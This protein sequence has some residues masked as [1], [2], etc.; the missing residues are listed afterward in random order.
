MSASVSSLVRVTVDGKFFRLGEKK[1][2]V[3]GVSYGPFAPDASGACFASPERTA[4]DFALA[5]ELGANVLRVYYVPPRWFLD[6]AARHDLRVWV[7]IPWNKHLCFLDSSQRRQEALNAVRQAVEGCG[8]HPA[9]FAFSVANEIPADIVRWSGARRVAEFIDELAAEAKRIDP[10]CL[11]TYGNFPPTEFLRPQALDFVSFNVYLH[12]RQPFKNYLARL[13]MIADA[14]PLVLGE[15]GVDSE[16]EGEVNKA[17]MLAWQIEDAFRGGL[18]GTVVFS[19]TDDWWRGGEKILDWSMG[20]TNRERAPKE[21]FRAVQELYALD[22]PLPLTRYPM[23]SVVVATYD[24]GRTLRACLDSLARLNYPNYEVILVDDGST[25]DTPRIVLSHPKIHYHRHPLNLGL[26]A[27]RNTGIG[28]A[29]GDIVAFTDSDCRPDEDWLHYLVG[30]L[31]ESDFA[32]IGGHNLLPP[33]ASPVSSAVMVSPGGPAHVMLTDRQAEHVPGCNMAFY[34]W[35]LEEIH[36]FDPIFRK[37]GDDVDLCWRLQ[38]R[39]WRIG[40][41][42]AGFVW[43]DRRST[44]GAYLRQQS[45]YGEAEALLVQKHPEYFSALGGGIWHGRIYASSKHGIVMQQPIVYHGAFASGM[46]QTLYTSEPVGILSFFTSLEY[47]VLVTLPLL[48][49]ATAFSWLMP[50]AVTSFALSLGV[51]L[52]AGIQAELPRNKLCWWSRPA[53]ALLFFLQPIVRGWARYQGQLVPSTKTSLPRPT[54]E[55]VTVAGQS[56]PLQEVDYWAPQG[57]NRIAFVTAILKE[58]SEQNWPCAP[59]IG[60]SNYDV[61][62]FGNRWTYLLLVTVVEDHPRGAQLLRCRLQAHWSLRAHAT[63]WSIFALEVLICGLVGRSWPWIWLLLVSLLVFGGYLSREMRHLQSIAV[64]FLDKLALR[65]N[66]TKL[67]TRAENAPQPPAG[68]RPPAPGGL[69][70]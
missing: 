58:L 42:A 38:Q 60:W 67:P 43:H 4:L 63:F 36:G 11:C 6:L 64:L 68:A 53:V 33:D 15:I 25:D 22:P 57:V 48:V 34:R 70:S 62:I 9:V 28:A 16:R 10:G 47:H 30:D 55:S 3:K 27:A 5:R 18:A 69:E 17:T 40:F 59:D 44:I 54:L 56:G 51:S 52:A 65:W 37:A 45:G 31:L 21:S 24:G 12:H 39:G 35:A 14:K 1:F 23:V 32:G 26:S 8:R 50:L 7:D 20:L 29:K 19:F 61:K 2:F 66:L 49:L 46:F 13:Q 41:N